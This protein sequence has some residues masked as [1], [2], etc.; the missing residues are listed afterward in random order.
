MRSQTTK[1]CPSH[2]NLPCAVSLRIRVV[3]ALARRRLSIWLDGTPVSVIA[4]YE[5][6]PHRLAD[7]A[8][9]QN[10]LSRIPAP[11][12]HFRRTL[13]H[14]SIG[15]AGSSGAPLDMDAIRTLLSH[16][17]QYPGYYYY[18][19]APCTVAR[20]KGFLVRRSGR[21][22]CMDMPTKKKDWLTIV[23]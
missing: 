6:S 8:C 3:G 15:C 23:S 10:F 16:A 1:L 21:M 17:L 18:I 20:P 19:P 14:M 4:S 7:T 13:H 5:C 12:S 22:R 2:H 9:S 11:H